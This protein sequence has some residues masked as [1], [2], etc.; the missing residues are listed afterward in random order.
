VAINDAPEAVKVGMTA[1]LRI[2]YA[3]KQAV[4]L[5]PASALLPRGDGRVVQ[6]PASDP[7][8]EP[9]EIA[10]ETGLSDGNY[11]EILSGLSE[12]Q[13]IIATPGQSRQ[14]PGGLFG[15]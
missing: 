6:V 3:E 11:T 14:G 12:G 2:I 4:L 15:Q 1:N 7:R 9:Q 8:G 13:Q 10:V 5:V